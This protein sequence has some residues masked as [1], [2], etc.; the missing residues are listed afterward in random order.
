ML[1]I[2]EGQ[3]KIVAFVAVGLELQH[4][5]LVEVL[6]FLDA[7]ELKGAPDCLL[8]TDVQASGFELD[9]EAG[10]VDLVV[11][12]LP[13]VDLRA[14]QLQSLVQSENRRALQLF[15]LV[16]QLFHFSVELLQLELS[17]EPLLLKIENFLLGGLGL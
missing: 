14:K 4:H 15:K 16:A 8:P 10:V 7:L 3:E 1:K 12:F 13:Y 17:I 11:V 6:H 2:V 9:L 5:A